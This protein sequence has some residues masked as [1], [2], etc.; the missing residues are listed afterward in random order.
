MNRKTDSELMSVLNVLDCESECTF[1]CA[2]DKG[3][4]DFLVS[5]ICKELQFCGRKRVLFRTAR[6]RSNR[7]LGHSTRL[8]VAEPVESQ[9][10]R[11]FAI[12][13]CQGRAYGGEATEARRPQASWNRARQ[14]GE[15][16]RTPHRR[17]RWS[18]H[19]QIHT[20]STPAAP[21]ELAEGQRLGWH[22]VGNGAKDNKAVLMQPQTV[23]RPVEEGSSIVGLRFLRLVTWTTRT[24]PVRPISICTE[25]SREYSVDDQ[26]GRV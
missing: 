25:S 4:G 19:C 21:S 11:V 22:S 23:E 10:R 1:A 7:S 3:P 18:Q 20:A 14:S 16:G 2:V 26:Q 17:R 6:H 24:I 13:C 5:V 8:L 12:R 15:V 9:A